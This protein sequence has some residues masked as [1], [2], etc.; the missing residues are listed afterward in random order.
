MGKTAGPETVHATRVVGWLWRTAEGPTCPDGGLSLPFTTKCI[1]FIN[2]NEGRYYVLRP[3]A[4]L[5]TSGTLSKAP[6]SFLTHVSTFHDIG[7]AIYA[8]IALLARRNVRSGLSLL[9]LLRR[10]LLHRRL[11]TRIFLGGTTTHFD[12]VD[13]DSA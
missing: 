9:P 8:I 10:H 2:T 4:G 5:T 11:P 7:H 13:G 1:S 12:Q 6:S 3:A